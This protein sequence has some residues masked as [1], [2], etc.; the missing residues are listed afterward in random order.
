MNI[1]AIGGLS[2]NPF[3]TLCLLGPLL[4]QKGRHSSTLKKKTVLV[5]DN[6]STHTSNAVK[7]KQEE[8]EKKGL[9]IFYLPTYSPQLNIIEI[10]WRFIKYS[11]LNT[12]AYESWKSLVK[13]VEDMLRDVGE[14]YKINFA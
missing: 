2:A 3:A 11:W 5:M 1:N 13:A 9:T 4:A 12:D 6:A 8:W 10:L 7:N 14:K